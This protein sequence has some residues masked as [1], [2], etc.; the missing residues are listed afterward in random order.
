MTFHFSR[1]LGFGDCDPAGIAYYPA[2]MRLLVSVTEDIF[3]QIGAPWP[4]M[5]GRRRLG[6][7]TLKLDVDF[8]S[9]AFHGDRLDF[10]SR[11]VGLGRSSLVFRHQVRVG[12][13][14]VWRAR[15]VL[16]G[17]SLDTHRPH[18]WPDDIRTGFAGHLESDD[19]Q[20]PAT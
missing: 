3:A 20:D 14:A 1:D 18:P 16:V 13:R 10:A 9:P 2:Y 11:L 12:E 6:V 15:H 4:D 17:T 8:Q 7:P 19:V 5:I